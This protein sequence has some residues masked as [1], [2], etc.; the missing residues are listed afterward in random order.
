VTASRDEVG[1]WTKWRLNQVAD[2]LSTKHGGQCT[3]HS[4]TRAHFS[5]VYSRHFLSIQAKD[6]LVSYCLIAY[7]A[8][9]Y[10]LSD[11]QNSPKHHA[12]LHLAPS[13]AIFANTSTQFH[14]RSDLT[15]GNG[16][17]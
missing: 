5:Q 11:V 15:K 10:S 2:T 1:E 12:D 4:R 3:S 6:W 16:H 17:I 14:F 7:I 13:P 9:T 8:K